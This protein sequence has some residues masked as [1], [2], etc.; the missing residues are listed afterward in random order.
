MFDF[1]LPTWVTYV[2]VPCFQGPSFDRN[3]ARQM[4]HIAS[5]PDALLSNR[6]ILGNSLLGRNQR[7]GV[8]IGNDTERF[9]QFQ[10]YASYLQHRVIQVVY[11][12]AIIDSPAV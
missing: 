2:H 9:D 7:V 1:I 4:T 11:D 3:D 10:G 12:S 5:S 8:E 6:I